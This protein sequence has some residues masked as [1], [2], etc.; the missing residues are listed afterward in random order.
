MIDP[1][2]CDGAAVHGCTVYDWSSWTECTAC[3]RGSTERWR[4]VSVQTTAS[5]TPRLVYDYSLA[6]FVD[7]ARFCAVEFESRT[8]QNPSKCL[9]AHNAL[10]LCVCVAVTVVVDGSA[11]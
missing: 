11:L 10:L 6:D 7:Y 4:V 8:C 3:V 2:A 1:F 5:T 9:G